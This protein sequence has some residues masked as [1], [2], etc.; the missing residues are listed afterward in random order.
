MF[1]FG[2]Y[3]EDV[4]E[5]LGGS[6]KKENSTSS[7]TSTTTSKDD[8]LQ[9]FEEIDKN[10]QDMIDKTANSQ[11]ENLP[12]LPEYDYLEYDA[13]DDEQIKQTAEDSLSDYL[14]SG[15]NAIEEES[16]LAKAEKEAEKVAAEQAAQENANTIA[17]NYDAANKAVASDTLKRG[18]ARSSIAVNKTSE[19]ETGKAEA[20]NAAAQAASAEQAKLDSELSALEQERQKALND[21][22]I[23]YA[24]KVTEKINELT[25]ER[26]EKIKEVTEYNNKLKEQ[27]NQ[28][29][30][31]RAELIL[32][33]QKQAAEN[34]EL[35]GAIADAE[36]YKY[37]AKYTA[38]YNFLSGLSDAKAKEYIRSDADIR[39]AL[40]DYYYYKLY[41]EFGR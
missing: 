26:D 35:T 18:L 9:Q 20:L 23:A 2:P 7:S 6:D 25:A 33:L 14:N 36:N 12:E 24:A 27:E 16:A 8:L 13:P 31:E 29:A 39:N 5:I 10:Y 32:E 22:D 21:F 40:T 4:L 34:G 17:S 28:D 11:L 30:E 37:E 15:K 41:N 1:D 19:I 38:I 3:L